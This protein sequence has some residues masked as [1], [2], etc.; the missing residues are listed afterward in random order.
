M[1]I[2]CKD[3]SGKRIYWVST[4]ESSNGYSNMRKR[5]SLVLMPQTIDSCCYIREWEGANSWNNERGKG[6]PYCFSCSINPTS[7]SYASPELRA[8][9][10]YR[11]IR[12]LPPFYPFSAT[13][14]VNLWPAVLYDTLC[15][16]VLV[17]I[18]KILFIIWCRWNRLKITLSHKQISFLRSTC[19]TVYYLKI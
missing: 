14:F 9:T 18:Q 5:I 2:K 16:A 3:V 8:W 12:P 6:N 11:V 15:Y 10:V 19:N 7:A 13:Y 4:H 1:F 17:K